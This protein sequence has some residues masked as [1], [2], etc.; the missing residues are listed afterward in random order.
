MKDKHKNEKIGRTNI[1]YIEEEIDKQTDVFGDEK[2][3]N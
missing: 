2:N 1:K 3:K